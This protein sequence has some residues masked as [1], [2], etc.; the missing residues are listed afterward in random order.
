[1]KNLTV[2]IT[3][4]CPLACRHCSTYGSWDRDD[5]AIS[6]REFTRVLRKN[7]EYKGI[8]LSGGEPFMH[9][10]ITF[11]L[12]IA[13]KMKRD[14]KVLSCGVYRRGNT[15]SAIQEELIQYCRGLVKSFTFSLHGSEKTHEEVVQVGNIFQFLDETVNRAIRAKIP[16][17]FGF[18]PMRTNFHDLE[19]AVKYVH[20][21]AKQQDYCTPDLRLSRYVKHGGNQYICDEPDLLERLALSPEENQQIVEQSKAL[22]KEYGIPIILPCSMLERGC[23]AGINKK[24]RT[25]YGKEYNCAALKWELE[26]RVS[27]DGEA[28]C[29]ELH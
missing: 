14:V 9:P 4:L 24:G 15:S 22:E 17:S 10:D 6:P 29:K 5:I 1:M 18:V 3:D 19:G 16:F 20:T 8:F 28:L 7:P 2:E 27:T 13:K 25:P 12:K 26:Q 23:T 21:K 11:L